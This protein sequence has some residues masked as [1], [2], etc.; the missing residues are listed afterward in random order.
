MSTS[1]SRSRAVVPTC[2]SS[3][4]PGCWCWFGFPCN[5]PYLHTCAT[6][7]DDVEN[8]IA[9]WEGIKRGMPFVC[10]Q[11]HHLLHMLHS[12]H[13]HMAGLPTRLTRLTHGECLVALGTLWDFVP[14]HSS[15]CDV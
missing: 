11:A 13:T 8:M 15:E 12:T 5:H 3:G 4:G 7:G 14:T 10:N 2:F 1:T 6:L 9:R